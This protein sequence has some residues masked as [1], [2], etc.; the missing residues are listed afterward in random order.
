MAAAA[1]PLRSAFL[2][3]TADVRLGEEA[4]RRIDDLDGAVRLV[5][6]E[7]RLVLP[8]EVDVADFL[9]HEG[10]RRGAGAEVEDGRLLVELLHEREGIGVRARRVA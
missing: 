8:C 4:D 3:T 10:R 5:H 1:V 9:L 2:V 7:V 6:F